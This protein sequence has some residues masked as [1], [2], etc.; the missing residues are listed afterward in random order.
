SKRG[1][2]AVGAGSGPGV[3]AGGRRYCLRPGGRPGLVGDL[4]LTAAGLTAAARSAGDLSRRVTERGADLVDL[5]LDGR[6][7][8]ALARLVGALL[9]ATGRDDPHALRQ[10]TRDVLGELA[11]HRRA[12]EQR[13]AVLPLVRL[14]V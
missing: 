4:R 5:E 9:Q 11:P 10:R 8:L 2:V 12:E 13:F 1:V 6:A 14:A 3:A 7:L